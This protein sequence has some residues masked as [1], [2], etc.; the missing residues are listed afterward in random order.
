MVSGPFGAGDIAGTLTTHEAAPI[1]HPRLLVGSITLCRSLFPPALEL[2]NPKFI[3]WLGF[4]GSRGSRNPFTGSL[5]CND[6]FL[7]AFAREHEQI[8]SF[9]A[10]EM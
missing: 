7:L 9:G 6:R 10:I 2:A 1:G 3:L 4:L 8:A 5:E